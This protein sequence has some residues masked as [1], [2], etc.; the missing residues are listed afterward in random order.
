MP[1]KTQCPYCR[2]AYTLADATRGKKVRCKS[3][4]Q[5]FEALDAVDPAAEVGVQAPAAVPPPLPR[6]AAARPAPLRAELVDDVTAAP[7]LRLPAVTGPLRA[8]L[9]EDDEDVGPARRPRPGAGAPSSSALPLI[10]VAS[11]GGVLL[12]AGVVVLIV[13]LSRSR[14]PEPE[15]LAELKVPDVND[16]FQQQMKRL[17]DIENRAKDLLPPPKDFPVVK[18]P[19]VFKAPS[20]RFLTEVP[21]IHVK[22]LVFAPQAQQVGLVYTEPVNITRKSVD[23]YDP[24]AGQRV[25]RLDIGT[26][27]FDQYVD[28]SPDGTRVGSKETSGFPDTPL[29]IW[30]VP[31]GK[32]LFDKWNPYQKA[33]QM[34]QPFKHQLIWFAFLDRDRLLTVTRRGQYDLA[35]IGD[36]RVLYTMPLPPALNRGL[37]MNGFSRRPQ[38]VA[39][40][41]DRK[42]LALTNKDGFDLIE[43]ATGRLL[44]RTGSLGL[45]GKVGN[46]WS[47]GF[48]PDGALLAAKLNLFGA[49][50]RQ[51]EY[52][53]VWQV[54]DGK[55]W[56]QFP[57]D[58]DFTL[59]G[60]L[61]WWGKK[62]VVLFNGIGKEG[63]LLDVEKGQY[64]R[65][66]V[67]PPGRGQFGT[68][69]VDGRLWYALSVAH[70]APAQIVAVDLPED[71]LARQPLPPGNPQLPRWSCLPEGLSR[72]PAF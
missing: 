51:Q 13:V 35:H 61:A 41:P 7:P 16:A 59:N 65:Q 15:I 3:C 49:N 55:L 45:I 50:N 46:E 43:T 4:Q 67:L 12:L 37:Q 26:A 39:L 28:V 18:A 57:L 62:H 19:E 11:I 40:S 42:V 58:Q 66:L 53:M 10:L 72:G 22:D 6:Q 24:K 48:S 25:V 29:S 63:R 20:T 38:N 44:R 56:K 70:G 47:V 2:T 34:G 9:V 69:A 1:V 30:S 14:E 21:D 33:N 71:E 23:L 27:P 60:P 17:K 64:Q 31:D 32:V 5:T 54:A 36:K 8:E 68:A 52:V